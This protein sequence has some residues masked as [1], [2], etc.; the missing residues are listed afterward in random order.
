LF[1][2][3]K[4]ADPGIEPGLSKGDFAPL[5]VWLRA[6][7]HGLGSSLTTREMLIRAT[8]KPLDAAVFKAHLKTRYLDG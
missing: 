1:A 7:W 6:H 2:A 4:K 8:G 3:A 5:M